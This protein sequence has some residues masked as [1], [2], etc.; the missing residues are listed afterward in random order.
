MEGLWQKAADRM[1]DTLDQVGFETWI[2]PLNFLRMQG[3][4]ATIEAPNRFFRDWVSDR[5]L[6]LIGESLS[7][8]A[9]QSV[10]VKLTLALPASGVLQ[11][12]AKRASPPALPVIDTLPHDRHPQLNARYTFA[13]FVIG[14]ANQFAHAAALAVTN[15]PGGKYNPLFIYGG[16][17]LG[18]THLVTAILFRN[19]TG[20]LLL[21][22][23][24]RLISEF[25]SIRRNRNTG[26]AELP[27]L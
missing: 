26:S 19:L 22:R 14:S 16:V 10:E 24:G 27:L 23:T 20:G 1:R 7:A 3:R 18:K 25:I 6:E 13:E 12:P 4:T 11:E 9:G 17:G 15:Q 8:E 21:L 5:Y 2:G